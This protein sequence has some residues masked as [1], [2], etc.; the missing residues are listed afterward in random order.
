MILG[1]SSSGTPSS[2]STHI[3][4]SAVLTTRKLNRSVHN[5][6]RAIILKVP[7]RS[8]TSR[9]NSLARG[10]T[11]TSTFELPP[12]LYR[13]CVRG[14]RTPTNGMRL[15]LMKSPRD[16]S[17]MVVPF[18]YFGSSAPP[19]ADCQAKTAALGTKWSTQIKKGNHLSAC[20]H[21][22]AM[23]WKTC[24]AGSSMLG[25]CKAKAAPV[26]L[27]MV[28]PKV[29]CWMIRVAG[30]SALSSVLSFRNASTNFQRH[31]YKFE[32]VGVDNTP[33][34]FPS[35][36]LLTTGAVT[37]WYFVATAGNLSTSTTAT[38]TTSLRVTPASAASRSTSPQ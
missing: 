36:Y 17:P 6:C 18:K 32:A 38:G 33:C 20:R 25:T 26:M 19:Y 9:L 13:S 37:T 1:K 4:I 7:P 15:A 10:K 16:A 5:G 31:R 14:F 8:P 30:T 28:C 27:A 12:L 29:R 35:L 23:V 21:C 34:C 22:S 2:S 24:T 3:C 11:K